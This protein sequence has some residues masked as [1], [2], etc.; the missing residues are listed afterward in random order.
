MW[1]LGSCRWWPFVGLF[2]F[3][4][5]VLFGFLG[6]KCDRTDPG[7]TTDPGTPGETEV[8]SVAAP[9]PSTSSIPAAVFVVIP[10]AGGAAALLSRR[11]DS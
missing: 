10:L 1:G 9:E 6:F 3:G 5:P 11:Q 4:L 8:L 7:V 2:L